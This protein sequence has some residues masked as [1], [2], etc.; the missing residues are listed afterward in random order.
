MAGSVHELEGRAA[1]WH[2]CVELRDVA[3][4]AD[5]MDDD[6]HLVLVEPIRYVQPRAGWLQTLPAYVVHEWEVLERVVDV[7][8][9]VGA[10]LQRVRMRATVRGQDRSGVF[11]LSDIWRLRD[12]AWRIW[13][14]HSTP[15][16]SG[17]MPA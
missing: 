9:E 14:R 3:G 4:A 7:D 12:G 17:A 15:L 10:L 1:A 6:F 11:I 5:F 16:S 2:A 13:R 8:G